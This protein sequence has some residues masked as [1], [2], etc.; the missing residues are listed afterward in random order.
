MRGVSD[1]NDKRGFGQFSG[2]YHGG[3]REH[4]QDAVRTT[5]GLPALKELPSHRRP[6]RGWW[7]REV[8]DLRRSIRMMAFA[9][10]TC[11]E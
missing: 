2:F 4:R 10:L 11:H 7:L 3:G 5:H 8:H 6:L 1:L 9:Q